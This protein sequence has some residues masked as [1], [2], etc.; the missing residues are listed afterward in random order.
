[1]SIVDLDRL[2]KWSHKVVL[3]GPDGSE[4]VVW[5]RILGDAEL[6]AARQFGLRRAGELRRALK[7]ES[8]PAFFSQI[9]DSD[10]MLDEELIDSILAFEG[11]DIRK[12]VAE[13]LYFP[14]PNKPGIDA[15]QEEEE[16]Y[17]NAYDTW[18][19]EF[20]QKVEEETQKRIE[21]RREALASHTREELEI[22][23][24][25]RM[26][27]VL[28]QSKHI[29]AFTD[30]ATYLAT[31]KDEKLRKKAFKNFD[32]FDNLAT[33]LKDQLRHAYLKLQSGLDME[34]L[35][36]SDQE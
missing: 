17:I 34:Y 1:M 18:R 14:P 29:D 24:R 10:F 7:D 8:S 35:K 21:A 2:F 28:C 19:E 33:E 4:A 30:Y 5:Q 3:T 23:F 11:V 26:V 16:E 20:N 13:T 27:D 32:E 6:Q 22:L 9:P 25:R 12:S 15:S 31:Y 36:K